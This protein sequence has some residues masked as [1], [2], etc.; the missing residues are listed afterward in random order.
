MYKTITYNKK[1]GCSGAQLRKMSPLR[2][3]G[4]LTRSSRTLQNGKEDQQHLKKRD[5]HE[6]RHTDNGND[7]CYCL[8][9]ACARHF[10][11][12]ITLYVAVIGGGSLSILQI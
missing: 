11:C 12:I 8:C 5:Q 10:I 1:P 3:K 4:I 2:E 7:H 6:Q 9:Q